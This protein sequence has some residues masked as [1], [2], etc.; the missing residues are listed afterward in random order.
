MVWFLSE[1]MSNYGEEKVASLKKE[2]GFTEIIFCPEMNEIRDQIG[3]NVAFMAPYLP[4]RKLRPLFVVKELPNLHGVLTKQEYDYKVPP[5]KALYARLGLK[6]EKPTKTFSN[7]G[8]ALRLKEWTKEVSAILLRGGRIKG[9]FLVGPTGSGKTNFV[10]AFAGEL[11]RTLVYLNL[12]LLMYM[13]NPIDK[14]WGVFSYLEK[15][16]KVGGK[17][18]VLA[19]EFEKMVDVEDGS[20]IQKQFLGQLLTI[21]NDFNTPSGFQI[22]MV[23]FATVNKLSMILDNNPE[24]LRHGRW[25]AKF[26]LN[27]PNEAEALSI[28]A[29]YAKQW[30]VRYFL[31]E[32]GQPKDVA[33]RQLYSDVRSTYRD[34]N[35]TA[36]LS[37]Y[38]PAEI[39]ALMERLYTRELANNGVL[40]DTI[41]KDTI[42]LIIPIQKTASM[43]VARQI[44]DAEYGFEE[45]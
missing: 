4:D 22:D 44:K 42:S 43:G 34:D 19:D 26:F 29:L 28:Y 9:A 40:S 23:M 30:G 12:P 45:C 37:V 18:V 27:Y 8:G 31:D 24:L 16:T 38:S 35:F 33:L 36:G 17:F 39:N 5:E 20:P 13:D 1:C 25:S 41:I 10:E 6:V 32:K 3:N 11:K 2:L 21:L 14:L 7:L 15:Q